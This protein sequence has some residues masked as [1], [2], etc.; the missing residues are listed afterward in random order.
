MNRQQEDDPHPRRLRFSAPFFVVFID[1][2]MR[3]SIFSSY[4]CDQTRSYL[5]M[6]IEAEWHN[7]L[8]EHLVH[9]SPVT[10][11]LC[12][13]AWWQFINLFFFLL[14]S[15]STSSTSF[16]PR[17]QQFYWFLLCCSLL[18]SGGVF[19]I[20]SLLLKT[21]NVKPRLLPIA[22][23]IASFGIEWFT[24]VHVFDHQ[25]LFEEQSKESCVWV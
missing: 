21:L 25:D 2:L 17:S 14:S 18:Y 19:Y 11:R 23:G 3:T 8:I 20:I 7:L 24:N 5:P 22:N 15:S 6:H 16:P 4:F 13:W 9:E 12:L 1:S 10:L